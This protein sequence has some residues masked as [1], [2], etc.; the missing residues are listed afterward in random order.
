MKI[1]PQTM[2][3]LIS[4]GGDCRTAPATPG[5]LKRAVKHVE[6]I[7]CKEYILLLFQETR[8]ADT[9]CSVSKNHGQVATGHSLSCVV[10]YG[11]N[12][13]VCGHI[14]CTTK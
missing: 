13:D 14:M 8:Q 10:N 5:L 7:N 12:C 11:V 2:T 9:E 1:F 3:E 4:D 6:L